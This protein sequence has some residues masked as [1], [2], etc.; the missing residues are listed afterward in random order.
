M[1]WG[2]FFQISIKKL[3]FDQ[4]KVCRL[5]IQR[6]ALLLEIQ[7]NQQF[8][9]ILTLEKCVSSIQYILIKYWIWGYKD[10]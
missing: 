1:G 4:L 8:A 7:H 3:S 5:L 9:Q 6:R 2:A 10:E